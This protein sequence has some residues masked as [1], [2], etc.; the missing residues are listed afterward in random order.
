MSLDAQRCFAL[1]APRAAGPV[2]VRHLTEA[3]TASDEPL[4]K[5]V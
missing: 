5:L 3:V 1:P 2:S 4:S